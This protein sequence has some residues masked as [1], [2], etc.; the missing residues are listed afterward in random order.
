MHVALKYQ[1]IIIYENYDGGGNVNH[2]QTNTKIIKYLQQQ[3]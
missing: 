1:S 3:K 2:Q